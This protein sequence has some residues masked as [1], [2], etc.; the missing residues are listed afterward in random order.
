MNFSKRFFSFIIVANFVFP[1]AI[2]HANVPLFDKYPKMAKSIPHIKFGNYPSPLVKV[3]ELSKKLG[4]KD[5]YIKDDGYS[6][7]AKILTGNK[8]RKLEFLLADA[9]KKG[10]KTVCTVGSAGSNHALETA[11]CAKAVGLKAVLVL[12]DQRQTS[13]VIR[14][15]KLM[16]Y[17]GAAII[18][19]PP[20]FDTNEKMEATC[21]GDL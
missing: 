3:E 5:L 16:V 2:L 10:Y 14:N 13:V 8:M 12:D 18:Y 17:F 9:L 6:S 21:T 4:I 15:L 19:A 11:I 7:D 1:Y 20:C